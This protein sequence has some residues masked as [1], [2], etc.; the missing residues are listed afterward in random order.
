MNPHTYT[1]TTDTPRAICG[2]CNLSAPD[3]GKRFKKHGGRV[4]LCTVCKPDRG[5]R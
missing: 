2:K 4:Y 1:L 5:G 3:D